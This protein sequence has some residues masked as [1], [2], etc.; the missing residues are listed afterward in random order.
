[1]GTPP[2]MWPNASIGLSRRCS[3]RR[4]ND[5][6]SVAGHA[7]RGDAAREGPGAARVATGNRAVGAKAH[8][9]AVVKPSLRKTTYWRAMDQLLDQAGLT[10]DPY[11]GASAALTLVA[12]P[13]EQRPRCGF[14]DYGGV[15]RFEAV[16]VE[17]MCDLCIPRVRGLMVR[18]EI[19]WEPRVA[20]VAIMQPLDR[21]TALDER[22]NELLVADPE[23]VCPALVRRGVPAVEIDL[24]LRLPGR[25]TRRIASLK[26]SLTVLLPGRLETFEFADLE[27]A[28]NVQQRKAKFTVILDQVRKNAAGCEVLLRLR[29]DDAAD[30]LGADRGWI[31]ENEAYL[32]DPRGRRSRK[33]WGGGD[34]SETR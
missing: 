33:H 4:R 29:F 32:V 8:A 5:E 27:T 21:L 3:R 16:R 22:G 20:P 26:G 11:G 12:R 17:T 2:P 28:R 34:G 19:N 1:M 7:R 24:P 9:E 10:I 30:S 23:G 15:F 13:V 31:C 18:L 25:S 6:P 14:A